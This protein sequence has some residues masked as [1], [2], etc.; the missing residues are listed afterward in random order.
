MTL[1]ASPLD[2]ELADR[3]SAP[4]AT[5]E[6][7]VPRLL[8]LLVAPVVVVASDLTPEPRLGFRPDELAAQLGVSKDL[9]DSWIDS[10]AAPRAGFPGKVRIIPA[11]WVAQALG[12]PSDVAAPAPEQPRPA[13]VVAPPR[14]T[15]V[16]PSR[17]QVVPSP[18]SPVR[19]ARKA[20]TRE[21]KQPAPAAWAVPPT[22]SR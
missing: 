13:Q 1:N 9:V 7:A 18:A 10:G 5:A 15:P 8:A 11:W 3:G 2:A 19:K 20:R 6:P 22:A 21:Q 17:L 12:D 4:S 14:P 16:V